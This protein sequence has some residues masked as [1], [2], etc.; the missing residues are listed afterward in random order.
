MHET[1][2]DPGAIKA[3]ISIDDVCCK[4][5]KASGRQKGSPP[6]EKREMVYNTVVH[7]QNEE[8]KVY[9][10]VS[11][12]ISQTLIFV[13]SFLLS[14]GMLRKLGSLVFFDFR[15]SRSKVCNPRH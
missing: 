13:L 6:K 7:I 1:F 2:E 14:N 4:E 10:A 11:P 15:C 9:T 3:N 12:T 5:Q 8:S